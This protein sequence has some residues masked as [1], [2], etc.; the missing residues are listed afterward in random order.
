[1]ARIELSPRDLDKIMNEEIRAK[2]ILTLRKIGFVHIAVDMEGYIQGSM[3][4]SGN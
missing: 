2:V 1:V 3:N 4:R